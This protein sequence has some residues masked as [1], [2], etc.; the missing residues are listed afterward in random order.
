MEQKAKVSFLPF[1]KRLMT[2]QMLGSAALQCM[3]ADVLSATGLHVE[4]SRILKKHY[5]K[6]TKKVLNSSCVLFRI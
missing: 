6:Q 2:Q 5:K 1:L 4:A 3:L